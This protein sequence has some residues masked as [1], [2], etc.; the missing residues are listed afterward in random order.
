MT[1]ELIM[2][3]SVGVSNVIGVMPLYVLMTMPC[4][5]LSLLDMMFSVAMDDAHTTFLIFLI[6]TSVLVFIMNYTFPR[7]IIANIL[8]DSEASFR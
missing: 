8:I 3:S 2:L 6:V 5:K 4:P 1:N 7:I